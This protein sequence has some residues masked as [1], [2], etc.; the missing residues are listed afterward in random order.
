MNPQNP[1]F[2]ATGD[3]V[4][5]PEISS[6]FGQVIGA[7]TAF[8]LVTNRVVKLL[9]VWLMAQ[10]KRSSKRRIRIIEL[11]PGRGT[12]MHDVLRVSGLHS[13]FEEG[14]STPIRSLPNLEKTGSP[15]SI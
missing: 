9:G 6:V 12:L 7:T 10:W 2:G 8:I 5:S 15:V 3:F 1:I 11:G 4:T 13:A 14:C